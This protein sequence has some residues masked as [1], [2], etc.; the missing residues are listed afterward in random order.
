L[1]AQQAKNLY[2]NII[3]EQLI[4]KHRETNEK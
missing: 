1:V 2:L 4:R 3:A